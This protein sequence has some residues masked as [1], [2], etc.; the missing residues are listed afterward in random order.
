MQDFVR[1]EDN[2]RRFILCY[3]FVDDMMIIYEFF[4]RNLGIVGG[5]FL[6]R[7][8]VVKFSFVFDQFIFYGFQDFYI[9]VVVDIF[10]YRFVIISVDEY[11]LKYMEE[12]KFQFL[13]MFILKL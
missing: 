5:K 11:V 9:G 2:G 10:K 1:F 13:G 12:Y 6:E 4:V 7:I 3:R 8:R